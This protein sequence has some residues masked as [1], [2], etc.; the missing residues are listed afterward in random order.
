MSTIG[1]LNVLQVCFPENYHKDSGTLLS[2][3]VSA[4]NVYITPR[5]IHR[6][7]PQPCFT[8]S[9]SE[10]LSYKIIKYASPKHTG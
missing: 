9:T 8:K 1:T 6:L 5:L 2:R 4:Q 10:D 3:S 7:N